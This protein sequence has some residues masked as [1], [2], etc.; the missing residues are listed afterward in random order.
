MLITS[1]A[2]ILKK[3]VG[4]S[5]GLSV[6]M[7]VSGILAIASPLAAGIAVNVFVGWLLVFSGCA[8]LA[9]AW[10]TKH[11]WRRHLGAAGRGSLRCHRSISTRASV[12]RAG[13][14]YHCA[15]DLSIPRDDPGVCYGI[16]APPA[17]GIRMA[18]LRWNHHSYPRCDDLENLA[19]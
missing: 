6:L 8:H 12:G 15:R 19:V 11:R 16:H 13:V 9:F 17:S 1:P 18:S 7:I 14:A 2:T 4:W 5:I 3:S 10:Y